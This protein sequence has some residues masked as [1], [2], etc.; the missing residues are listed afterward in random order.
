MRGF[1]G[2]IGEREG[3]VRSMRMGISMLGSL[4]IIRNMEMGNFF[5]SRLVRKGQTVR[6]L[7]FSSFVKESGG[8]VSLMVR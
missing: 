8:V 2:G 3:D 5:G 1:L 6:L 4:L 7:N